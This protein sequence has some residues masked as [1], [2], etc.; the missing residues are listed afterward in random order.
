VIDFGVI[1]AYI[2]VL[3]GAGFL[4]R[5]VLQLHFPP[6]TTVPTKLAAQAM[7]F[8]VLTLPVILYFALSESSRRQATIGK[9]FMTLRVTTISGQ[10]ISAGRSLL[11]SAVKFAPW[12][13]AHTAIWQIPGQPFVSEP[14]VLN[15]VG[16]LIAMGA[17][18]W[19]VASLFVGSR[20]T[21]YDRVAGTKVVAHPTGLCLTPT[22]SPTSKRGGPLGFTPSR[23]SASWVGA[24]S[25]FR[26]IVCLL[27]IF[28]VPVAR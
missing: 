12:E 27:R 20:R 17:V 23:P 14:T 24:G 3:T 1:A 28:P 13:L 6:P 7:V 4:A 10:R 22:N 18:A 16:F 26:G 2:G 8:G 9:R 5:S 19:Y 25:L 15:F 11:R 21:P